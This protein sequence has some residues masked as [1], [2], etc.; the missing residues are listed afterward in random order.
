MKRFLLAV[1]LSFATVWPASNPARASEIWQVEQVSKVKKLKLPDEIVE[2]TMA[3]A[4]SGIDDMLLAIGPADSDVKQAW[5]S[6]PT[7]RYSHAILGDRTEGG[8]LSVVRAD[9][10]RFTYRLDTLEVFEDLY[11]RIVDLDGDG[12]AEIVT[13]LTSLSAGASIALFGLNGDALIKKAASPF[14]GRSH[15]WLNIAGIANFTGASTPEIAFVVTPHIGGTL[16][17]ARYS[18]GRFETFAAEK[19]FSN[20][21]IRTSELRLSA[22]GDFNGDGR[23][24]LALPSAD[25]KTLRI[26]GFANLRLVEIASAQLPAAIDKAIA[27]SGIGRNAV[28]TVGLED[29]SV[30]EVRR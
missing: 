26:M 12:K 11:P 23:T 8:A 25:R 16:A 17:F 6:L 15:R 14:I 28:L 27:V 30:Y 7:G 1:L 13:I 10:H 9:G 29:G 5:Y 22:T 3:A 18:N 20:H 21:V 2:Q 24:D 19:G 4:P